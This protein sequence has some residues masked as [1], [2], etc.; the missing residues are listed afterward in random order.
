MTERGAGT[1]GVLTVRELVHDSGLGLRAATGEMG[2]GKSVKGI[3]F[4]DAEDPVPYLSSESVLVVTGRGFAADT[5]AGLRLLDRL[6]TIDTAALAI[7]MGHFVESVPPELVAR[8]RDLKMPVLEIPPGTLTRTV[9]SYVYH[10]LASG[11]LHRLRRTVA[12]QTNLLD[13]LIAD[14]DVEELLAQVATL[15]GMPMLS[16]DGVGRVVGSAG[17]SDP[18]HMASVAWRSWSEVAGTTAPMGIVEAGEARFI[19]REVVLYGKLERLLVASASQTSSSEFVDTALSFLQRLATLNVLRRRDEIVATQ[20]MRQRL[21]RDLL[22]GTASSE[23]L[24][25]W[26]AEHGLDLSQPWRVAICDLSASPQAGHRR[27]GELEDALV[28]AVD[29]YFGDRLVP[30][31]SRP[32]RVSITVL[33]PNGSASVGAGTARDLLLG[34]KTFAAGEPYS[35]GVTIGCSGVR[36]DPQDGPRA[37]QEALDA[38]SAARRGIDAGGLVLFEEMSGRFRLLEGQSDDALADIARRTIAPLIDYDA[39]RHAHL[40][41]TLRTWLDNHW[42]IQ[43]TAEALFIHRNTLQKRLRRIETLLGVDLQDTDDTM[44]LYLGLRATQLLGEEAVVDRAPR[45]RR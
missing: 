1:S 37:L 44:E 4:S 10:A 45:R 22:T 15:I 42:A 24:T 21:L 7:A 41:A 38:T 11:D 35:L 19:C 43:P 6:V 8:A 20:R 27:A 9:F 14:A 3:H 28:E 30:F 29:T 39:R 32:R 16:L 18:E 23:E 12:M 2:L 40:V 5:E 31:L 17:V 33:L 34:L 13:L 36:A 25:E 26:V